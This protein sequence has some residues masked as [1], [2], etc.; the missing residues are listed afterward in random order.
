MDLLGMLSKKSFVVIVGCGRLGSHIA[1]TLSKEGHSVVVV[2]LRQKSFQELSGDF[3][4]FSIPGDA[5]EFDTL[6]QAKLDKADVLIAATES[7]SV[8]MLVAQVA[9]KI[10]KTG[11]VLARVFDRDRQDLCTRLGIATV[12][13]ST[14]VGTIFLTSLFGIQQET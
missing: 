7:D 1:N 14:V 6:R 11:K 5:T 10:F 9:A 3:S 12:C 4:G 2:D 8:N 13:P